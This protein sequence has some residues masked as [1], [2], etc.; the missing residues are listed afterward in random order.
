MNKPLKCEETTIRQIMK[1]LMTDGSVIEMR[2]PKAGKYKTI[3]GYFNHPDA[4]VESAAKWNGQ[5]NLYITLNKI[6]PALLA[7]RKNRAET[8]AEATTSDSDVIRLRWLLV[9]F[10]PQRSAGISATDSEHDAALQKAEECRKFLNE[11]H[12]ISSVYADSGN[13][14]HLLIPIDLPNEKPSS[15]L[16]KAMLAGL[17]CLF[18]DER[19][20]VDRT[21][22]NASRICKLYGTLSVKGDNLP[23]RPHRLA[24]I[25][26]IPES[27]E[28]VCSDVL[29]QI[30][31]VIQVEPQ[32]QA[33]SKGASHPF[34]M[35]AYLDEHGLKVIA[36]T[37]YKEG[38][39]YQLAACP[40]NP[41]HTAKEA[42]VFLFEDGRRAFHCFHNSCQDKNW[43]SLR[44]L[45]EPA[46]PQQ[47]T[48]I[49]YN[50]ENA[51]PYFQQNGALWYRRPSAAGLQDIQLSNFDAR[52]V[53][54]V[55]EDDGVEQHRLL[56]MEA[57]V[58]GGK[59][60]RFTLSTQDYMSMNWP[61]KH[62]GS[63]AI[64]YVG[65]MVKENLKVAIQMLS[66]QAVTRLVYAH[67]GWREVEDSWY[68][69]HAGGAIGPNGLDSSLMVKLPDQLSHWQLPAPPEGQDL[70]DAI[71]ASLRML[72]LAKD[73]LIFP[74]YA[75]IWRSALRE[76]DFSIHLFGQTGVFKSELATLATR[77]FAPQLTSR[78]LIG[79]S[80]TANALTSL[81]FTGKDTLMPIDDYVPPP[82]S[83]EADR[84]N[85]KVETV[86]RGQGNNA[87]RTRMGADLSLRA[88]K[89]PR[90]LL[91][92]TGEDIPPGESAR[93]RTLFLS[94]APGDVDKT[95]LTLCQKEGSLYARAMSGYL[96]RVAGRYE[97]M[98]AFYEEEFAQYR[99]RAAA[100]MQAHPRHA[101]T[102]AH[103]YIGLKCFLSFAKGEGAIN[104]VDVS[105]LMARAWRAL[106]VAGETQ[107][108]YVKDNNPVD[109]FFKLLKAAMLAGKAY[110]AL[111]DDNNPE[112]EKEPPSPAS[113]GWQRD[114]HGDWENRG[115]RIGWIKGSDLYLDTE[116]S[117]KIAKEMGPGVSI[118]QATLAKRLHE[119]GKLA[120]TEAARHT[121]HVRRKL[122]GA[123]QAV[124]HLRPTD[125]VATAEEEEAAELAT[126]PYC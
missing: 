109:R 115:I 111:V 118:Q 89:R 4:L 32:S 20:T 81:L 45:L 25:L 94:V 51:S 72:K 37:S 125:L 119:Q 96:K 10:D 59:P 26:D 112:I 28:P 98:M 1:I 77:H 43:N 108:A 46:R 91:L 40:F 110:V 11:K 80:G 31:N 100:E 121:F 29:K 90:G 78:Q 122:A 69:L 9:D 61:M 24:R 50:E 49:T 106:I 97:K 71:H 15:D 17:G 120:S 5:A 58:Q 101:D 2:A 88:D 41:E 99:A 66:G 23:E 33:I 86:L 123:T 14:G 95:M 124:W 53:A 13:G 113:W 34:D 19:V 67:L 104:E 47:R 12:G 54:D 8:Y 48:L 84:L 75:A 114:F 126:L 30:A 35:R 92:S 42:A 87:S 83:Y 93:A 85:A 21:T 22:Y 102:V 65:Q 27:L 64:I 56:E 57:T 70:V 74:I 44:N 105:N 82:G 79:W 68:Y 38:I 63:N 39:R 55:T 36:E 116:L 76:A 3:S 107:G 73:E 117:Y 16:L 103:L 7:R 60:Q 62:L 6:N 18:D 52:I